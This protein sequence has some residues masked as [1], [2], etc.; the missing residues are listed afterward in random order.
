MRFHNPTQP[1]HIEASK[2]PTVA[3]TY[4]GRV[5]VDHFLGGG[6]VRRDEWVMWI[7]NQ[8]TPSIVGL[9]EPYTEDDFR[10]AVHASMDELVERIYF[11]L[12]QYDLNIESTSWNWVVA[13]QDMGRTNIYYNY[14]DPY[15]I[16][17]Y[18][19]VEVSV[20]SER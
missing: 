15:K 4:Y 8:L 11:V 9:V 5:P 6:G 13:A 16:T 10:R 20:L 18:A 1:S 2:T 19:Y 3:V 14:V 12:E 17:A 7:A